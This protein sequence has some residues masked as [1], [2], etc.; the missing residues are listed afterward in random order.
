MM[1]L[2][3]TTILTVDGVGWGGG[4]GGVLSGER[5]RANVRSLLFLASS[6]RRPTFALSG[7]VGVRCRGSNVGRLR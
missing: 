4:S 1:N 7:P 6:P 3:A 2:A 5:L